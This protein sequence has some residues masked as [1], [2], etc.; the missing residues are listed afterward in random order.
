MIY[1]QFVAEWFDTTQARTTAWDATAHTQPNGGGSIVSAGE[2]AAELAEQLDEPLNP[3]IKEQAAPAKAVEQDRG[4]W[5]GSNQVE[6]AERGSTPLLDAT[7][8]DSR[9]S[10]SKARQ[11]SKDDEN[12]KTRGGQR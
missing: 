2:L 7:E 8:A 1:P 12:D 3:P 5:W 6:R 11:A 10:R 9:H 4:Q